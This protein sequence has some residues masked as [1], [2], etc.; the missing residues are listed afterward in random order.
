MTKKTRAKVA[1]AHLSES[2]KGPGM[3]RSSKDRFCVFC[4]E[5]NN[6][7]TDEGLVVHYWNDCAML[8]NCSYC[9]IVSRHKKK[10]DLTP[11]CYSRE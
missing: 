11:A 7:F 2:E 8:A 3:S 1:P 9:K 10:K 4:D 6:A 5:R